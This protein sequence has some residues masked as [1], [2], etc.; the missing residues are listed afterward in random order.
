M[1]IFEH[2]PYAT[3]FEEFWVG[4]GLKTGPTC[5]ATGLQA[6][7]AE[8]LMATLAKYVLE[9]YAKSTEKI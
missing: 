6:S 8:R 3:A 7:Y 1:A 9:E 2:I 4:N 5:Y